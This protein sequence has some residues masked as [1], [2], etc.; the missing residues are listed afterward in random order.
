MPLCLH[1]IFKVKKV[2]EEE[3][4]VVHLFVS[5]E[6]NGNVGAEVLDLRRPL[7]GDILQRVGRVDGE[8]HQD[9]VRVGVGQ[10]SQ[11]V[12]LKG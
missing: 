11:P 8:T 1:F 3:K 9:H 2:H 4:R 7:L 12:T 6:D 10:R 5:H